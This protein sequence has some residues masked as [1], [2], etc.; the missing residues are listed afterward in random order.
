MPIQLG[1][2]PMVCY[3]AGN[4]WE[5]TASVFQ[6]YEGFVSYP[7]AGY[8]KVYFDGQHW[9]LKGQLGNR[10][11]A[12]R[13]SFATGIRHSSNLAGFVVLEVDFVESCMQLL[14][15]NAVLTSSLGEKYGTNKRQFK[16]S[17]S[18]MICGDSF[19][20]YWLTVLV[21]HLWLAIA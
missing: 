21:S 5:W 13:S 3:D 8:S 1:R 4:V 20:F 18:G 10:P 16:T 12:L 2:V 17:G 7:Y 11:W 6:G 14:C 15:A 9:V 19:V